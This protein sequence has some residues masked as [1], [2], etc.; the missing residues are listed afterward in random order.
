MNH[1]IKYTYVLRIHSKIIDTIF[2]RN[3]WL[4]EKPLLRVLGVYP[5]LNEDLSLK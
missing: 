1:I 2:W 4:K 3:D 5:D